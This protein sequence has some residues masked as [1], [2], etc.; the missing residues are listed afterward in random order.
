MSYCPR[1]TSRMRART[2]C[3]GCLCAC[4]CAFALA[5]ARAR[6]HLPCLGRVMAT[7][8][9]TSCEAMLEM[10]SQDVGAGDRPSKEAAQ[11][12]RVSGASNRTASGATMM[13]SEEHKNMRM[14]TWNSGWT[15]RR[16]LRKDPPLEQRRQ[17]S[18]SSLCSNWRRRHTS[19]PAHD[20]RCARRRSEH[21]REL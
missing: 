12:Q 3:F 1:R 2:P 14:G 17:G 19:S 11:R 10:W 18:S 13:S 4:S 6:E 5:R 20:R 21:S 8:V 16:R 7:T 15:A 9:G